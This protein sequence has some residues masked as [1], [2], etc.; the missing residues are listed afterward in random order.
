[1]RFCDIDIGILQKKLRGGWE[2]KA[3]VVRTRIKLIKKAYGEKVVG[4]AKSLILEPYASGYIKTRRPPH[5]YYN[6]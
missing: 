6:H 4:G 5:M 3:P 1:M 2:K